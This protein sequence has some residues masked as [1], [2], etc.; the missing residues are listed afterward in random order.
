MKKSG[1]YIIKNT[2]N[3]LVYIGKSV[4]IKA[5]WYAHK[6]FGNPSSKLPSYRTKIYPAMRAIGIEHFYLEVLEYCDF[7]VLNER[8]CYW[9]KKYNSYNNGYNMTPG[10]ESHVGEK[11]GRAILNED[12]VLEIRLMYG[13]KIRFREAYAKFSNIISKRGFQKVWHYKTWL[14]IAPEVYTDEN[15]KWHATA[16]KSGLNGNQHLG[17]NNTSRACSEEEISKMRKLR[18]QGFSYNKIAKE[19]GRSPSVVRKYCLFQEAKNPQSVVGLLVQ[20][21]ETGLVFN[22]MTEAAKWA[23]VYYTTIKRHLNK[24]TPAGKV[25]TTDEPAHWKTL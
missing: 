10:G 14:H 5:R 16:S 6:S 19:L 2:K 12:Q 3:N 18:N 20:N 8:E 4:D 13:N 7:D 1:I 24:E 11:N 17:K 22:S 23:G 25:P 9:I 21:V 15:R